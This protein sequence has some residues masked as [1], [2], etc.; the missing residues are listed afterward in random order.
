M[1]PD[2]GNG[3]RS[4][5]DR[6]P[7]QCAARRVPA[8]R[9]S[10]FGTPVEGPCLALRPWRDQRLRICTGYTATDDHCAA[11]TIA[12]TQAADARQTLQ[13]AQGCD[14]IIISGLAG[15]AGFVGL[16]VAERL[17]VPA[18]GAGMIPL[19]PSREFPSPFLPPGLGSSHVEPGQPRPD[20]PVVVA[21]AEESTQTG[22]GRPAEPGTQG[23]I[24]EAAPHALRHIAQPVAAPPGLGRSRRTLRPV[25]AA[26]GVRLCR[27]APVDAV[28]CR[29]VGGRLRRLWQ[30]DRHRPA[31][32]ASHAHRCTERPPSRRLARME[33]YGFNAAYAERSEH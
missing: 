21:G 20:R 31:A 9:Q 14:A 5:V 13:A 1:R 30:Y 24:L 10:A 15:L 8:P 16:S 2:T 29:R 12:Q 18:I 11:R 28:P 7:G 22:S 26:T 25:G 4:P 32:H 6:L 27:A 23:K 3:S 17:A 19:T 33:R